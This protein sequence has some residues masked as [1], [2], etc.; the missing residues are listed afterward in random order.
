MTATF[1]V[2][3][4]VFSRN[5]LI[6][7]HNGASGDYPGCTDVAYQAAIRDG[8]DYI[9][10][11]VQI[12]KDG[13]PICRESPDLTTGTN[14]LSNSVYYPSYL[15]QVQGINKMVLDQANTDPGIFTFDLTWKEI[16]SLK[17]KSDPN[18]LNQSK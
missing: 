13:V 17:R 10:C 2:L 9:D 7:S 16:Q 11:S 18:W 3:K 4:L 1:N 14:I 6:I 12:T 15:K 5:P 8:A